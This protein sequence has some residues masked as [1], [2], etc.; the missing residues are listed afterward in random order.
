MNY[1]FNIRNFR[2]FENEVTSFHIKPITILTGCNSSG[3][4]SVIKS[5]MLLSDYFNQLGKE[6]KNDGD[7]YIQNHKLDFTKRQ[8]K[9][10]G[11]FSKVL[12]TK[13]DNWTITFSY[14]FLSLLLAKDVIVELSFIS[15]DKDELNNG[16]L[17]E[18]KMKN[19]DGDT[20][21][22][23]NIDEENKLKIQLINMGLLKKHFLDF[24]IASCGFSTV[25]RIRMCEILG[26]EEGYSEDVLIELLSEIKKFYSDTELTSERKKCFRKWHEDA[27]YDSKSKNRFIDSGHWNLI[28][29]CLQQNTVFPLPVFQWLE[30]CD[31]NCTRTIIEDKI[32]DI[33]SINKGVLFNLNKLLSDFEQSNFKSLLDYFLNKEKEGLIFNNLFIFPSRN[34]PLYQSAKTYTN[35]SHHEMVNAHPSS[36]H[37]FDLE[38]GES[39]SQKRIQEDIDEFEYR[40]IDF[41]FV[42]STLMDICLIADKEFKNIFK[43]DA[44]MRD[45]YHPSYLL[46]KEYFVHLMREALTPEFLQDIRF[47]GSTRANVQRLYTFDDQS[48]DFNEL[49][50]RYFEAKKKFKGKSYIPDSFMN[51]WVRRFEIGDSVKLKTA[52]EGLGVLLYLYKDKNDKVGRL[53]AEEGYGITQLLSLLIQIETTILESKI[54]KKGPESKEYHGHDIITEDKLIEH[55]E[56]SILAIEEPEIHLHPKLQSQLADMF[57]EAYKNFNIHFI[58]ETH[59]EYL[60]RKTQVLVARNNY[61]TNTE[62]EEE[63]PFIT[64]YIPKDEKPYSLVYRR[65][66]K[67][68]N[69]FGEGFYDEASNLTFEIL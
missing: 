46:F 54:I 68:A 42:Y 23:A 52:E 34:E 65:D 31:K 27:Y 53:L 36:Y 21:F 67:F 30:E 16:W 1:E 60:I 24:A 5:L 4:S 15:L 44:F 10:L 58:V 22:S 37:I 39:K 49:L 55:F 51:E 29:I 9:N 41:Q 59:S 14:R 47:V 12:N 35:I 64:Y 25:D 50:L 20:I 62:T 38:T 17:S 61:S 69:K 45:Y 26:T 18:I 19:E 28:K 6:Y 48:S 56:A 43:T 2:I 40:E 3:K 57:Y 7:Y 32:K 66:G 13:S 33:E 11:N 63:S 8:H